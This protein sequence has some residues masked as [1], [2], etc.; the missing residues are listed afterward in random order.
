MTNFYFHAGHQKGRKKK[1][2]IRKYYRKARHAGV[3][4]HL[5]KA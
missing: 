1:K 3:R 4:A 2:L 5:R